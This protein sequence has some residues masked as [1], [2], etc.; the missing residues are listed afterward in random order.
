MIGLRFF[1]FKSADVRGAG[2]R[3]EPLRISAAEAKYYD[4]RQ[5][6]KTPTTCDYMTL[7]QGF[8]LGKE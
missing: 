3:D 1:P 2:T 7:C 5:K 4:I 8:D 6:E